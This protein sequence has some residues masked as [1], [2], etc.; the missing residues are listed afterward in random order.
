MGP[1]ITPLRHG[2]PQL[3]FAAFPWSAAICLIPPPPQCADAARSLALLGPKRRHWKKDV[4][5]H[6]S[7]NSGQLVEWSPAAAG[8]VLAVA[9][10][11]PS[12]LFLCNPSSQYPRPG[13][14]QRFQHPFPYAG[15]RSVVVVARA[16]FLNEFCCS[17]SGRVGHIHITKF[18]CSNSYRHSASLSAATAFTTTVA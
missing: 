8:I 16:A 10:V 18:L 2:D 9:F 13:H 7:R 3:A 17:L 14:G 4:K 15:L 6:C 12:S 5:G 11:L 1:S